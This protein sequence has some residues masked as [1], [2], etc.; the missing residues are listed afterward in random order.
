MQDFVGKK[1]GNYEIVELIGRGG[2][3]A[4]YKGFQPSM[5]RTVAVKVLAPQFSADES[6][7]RRFKN[8]AQTIAQLEHKHILPV[9]DFGEEGGV[10]FIVMRYLEGGVLEDLITPEGMELTEV[11]KYFSQIASALHYA[12]GKG[13]VHRDLKPSNVMVDAQ[14]D[15]FLMDFGI[16]KVLAGAEKLTGTGGVVGTPTY[17]APEQCAGQEADSRMDVYALGVMLFE[18]LTGKP[19]F[20]ADNP[21]A[22]MLRH[23]NDPAPAPSEFKPGLSPAIDAVVLRALTK[24]P[25]ERYQTVAE[26]AEAFR[27]AVLTATGVTPDTLV[28][29]ELAVTERGTRPFVPAPPAAPGTAVAGPTVPVAKPAPPT[30]PVKR[31]KLSEWLSAHAAAGVWL[32]ALL[33]SAATFLLLMRLTSG[34]LLEAAGLSLIP[35]LLLY[36][37]LRAPTLGALVSFVLVLLPLLARAPGV[38]LVWVAVMVVAAARLHTHEILLTLVVAWAAGSPL[39]WTIPLLA[40]WWFKA[41]KS[42]LPMAMGVGLAI[43]M[44][45]TMGWP[46]GGGLLIGP[47]MGNPSQ[48]VL[49]PA[50]TSYLSLFEPSGWPPAQRL[51][52]AITGTMDFLRGELVSEGGLPLMVMVSWSLAAVLSVSN[53]RSPS[54]FLRPVG[55]GLALVAL[56]LPVYRT[57]PIGS[58]GLGVASVIPAFLLSQWPIQSDPNKGNYSS[59]VLRML[60]QTLGA[61]FAAAGVTYYMQGNLGDS[62]LYIPAYLGALAG[63]T[64]MIVNPLIGSLLV[65][66]SLAVGLT[67]INT[68]QGITLLV[69]LGVY[70]VINLFLDR[71]RP[72]GWNP[73]GTGALIGAPGLAG[74]GL[75][76]M[77]ALSMGALETQVPAALFSIATYIT[78]WMSRPWSGLAIVTHIVVALLGVLLVERLMD[79]GL[80]KDLGGRLRRLLF[81]LVTAALMAIAL[82]TLGGLGG[83]ANVPLLTVIMVNLIFGAVLVGSMGERATEWQKFVEPEPEEVEE[84]LA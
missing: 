46:D 18:M 32:E 43:L 68:T 52:G 26:F 28:A 5:N 50:P 11:Y 6:F 73:I 25:E 74:A 49:G 34:N 21:M 47:I 30:I 72:R 20:M 2:M 67:P 64:A 55:L 48:I 69:L 71:R 17:M 44:A 15:S 61:L 10:L 36:G 79:V 41:R 65:F 37:L 54:A 62:S 31:N 4:V 42:A 40:P 75:M 77:T 51:L 59:T 1:L 56:L 84:T 38:A 39:G 70:V 8:E 13:V 23:V 33:L 58:L 24:R 22:L 60:R 66:V 19:P 12:H 80:L 7:I 82:Y 76:P 57:A 81:T 3:A 27:D 35:G 83:V 63:V 9:Y 14:G 16:A 53:R 29:L 45:M 78:L